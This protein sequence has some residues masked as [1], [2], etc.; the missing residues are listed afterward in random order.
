MCYAKPGPRCAN[1]A[2]KAL[3]NARARLGEL[4]K[5][6]ASDDALY[7]ANLAVEIAHNNYYATSTM[8]KKLAQRLDEVQRQYDLAVDPQERAELRAQIYKGR[9]NLEK[10][11]KI[12]N[13]QMK[14]YKLSQ[15]HEAGERFPLSKRWDDVPLEQSWKTANGDEIRVYTKG[16][17]YRAPNYAK[18]AWRIRNGEPVAMV[19]FFAGEEYGDIAALCDI[20][21]SPLARG[22]GLAL[23]T[24][25]ELDAK[26]G[27]LH[28]SGYYSLSGHAALNKHVP[29]LPG[30][31]V[32]IQDSLYEFVDWENGE[33]A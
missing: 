21:V 17:S 7:K 10:Y 26:Y 31:T 3:S 12:Y 22:E 23:D 25:R 28:T 27:Q 33:L 14:D 4:V 1:H 13:K 9:E 2:S 5:A 15:R 8:R 19:R 30:S 18:H 11:T 20:E 32:M 6:G 24:V 29:L 16:E